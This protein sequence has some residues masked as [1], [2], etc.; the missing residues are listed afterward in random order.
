MQDWKGPP[1]RAFSAFL[2]CLA[3][4]GGKEKSR[5][6]GPARKRS[7]REETD[8]SECFVWRFGP[9][10]SPKTD[11]P[12][13]SVVQPGQGRKAAPVVLPGQEGRKCPVQHRRASGERICGGQGGGLAGSHVGILHGCVDTISVIG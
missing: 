13:Q 5:A 9:H 10:R 7:V 4:G 11:I 12:Q 1:A 6:Q 2:L 8:Q 3:P